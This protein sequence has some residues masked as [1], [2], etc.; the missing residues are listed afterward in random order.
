MKMF[1]NMN[2]GTAVTP[3]HLFQ[4]QILISKQIFIFRKQFF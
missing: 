4:V 2:V 3:E 1:N